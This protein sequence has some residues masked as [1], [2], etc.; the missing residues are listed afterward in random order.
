MVFQPMFPFAHFKP[1][2]M[3]LHLVRPLL[4]V[5]CKADFFLR[6]TTSFPEMGAEIWW[7]NSRWTAHLLHA[8]QRIALFVK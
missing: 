8:E 4:Y 6:F 1:Y 7:R 3:F 2:P 5:H